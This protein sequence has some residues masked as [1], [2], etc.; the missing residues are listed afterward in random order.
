L[1]LHAQVGTGVNAVTAYGPGYIEVNRVRHEGPL[2]LAPDQ[3]PCAWAV[4]SWGELCASSFESV[5]ALL[6]EV[7]LLGSGASQH[8]P[9]AAAIAPLARAGIGFESMD[10]AAACRTFNI[11]AG[12]GR[13]VVGALL[14]PEATP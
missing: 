3:P 6:P 10:T 4:G 2:L 14:P 7:V 9:A 5:L 11:L 8:F 12:E 1:K 13:R